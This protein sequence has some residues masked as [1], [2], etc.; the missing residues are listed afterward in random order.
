M[1]C[2]STHVTQH[3]GTHPVVLRRHYS[4]RAPIY[5]DILGHGSLMHWVVGTEL[6][7]CEH[8]MYSVLGDATQQKKLLY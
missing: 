6:K 3:D 5:V 2:S 1:P 7:K 4:V 8:Y